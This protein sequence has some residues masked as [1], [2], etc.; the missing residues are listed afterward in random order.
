[1]D[2]CGWIGNE[3]PESFSFFF[4]FI[5]LKKKTREKERKKKFEKRFEHR[6]G[7]C[8]FSGVGKQKKKKSRDVPDA[9]NFVIAGYGFVLGF[10]IALLKNCTINGLEDQIKLGTFFSF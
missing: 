4:F 1:M 8:E 9:S 3:P 5:D 10:D 2:R 6:G 7:K